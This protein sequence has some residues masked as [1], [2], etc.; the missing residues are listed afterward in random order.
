MPTGLGLDLAKT[1]TTQ[2]EGSIAG[3]VAQAAGFGQETDEIT[4]LM[5]GPIDALRIPLDPTTRRL[6]TQATFHAGGKAFEVEL[7]LDFSDYDADGDGGTEGCSGHTGALPIC[8]RV[9]VAGERYLEGQIEAHP[10]QSTAGAG[11]FTLSKAEALPGGEA[12]MAVSMRYNHRT[13][14]YRS[15]DL[16]WAMPSEDPSLGTWASI[17]HLFIEQN[18]APAAA[19]KTINCTN[20]MPSLPD[21]TLRYLGRYREDGDLWF[22]SVE[23]SGFFSQLGL[24]TFAPTCVDLTTGLQVE[25]KEC[26]AAGVS[27]SDLSSVH[28]GTEQDV[29]FS[30]GFPASPTF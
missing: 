5:L 27:F 13:T 24:K 25:Q 4:T 10:T 1:A 15:T 18:G 8:L 16:F 14:D 6:S 2:S 22:G 9:W 7:K 12:G 28:V 11:R 21:T 29:S 26:S 23:A 3:S 30:A 17:R 19:I 20:I